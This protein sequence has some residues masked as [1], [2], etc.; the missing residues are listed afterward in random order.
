MKTITIVGWSA[1]ARAVVEEVT[2]WPDEMDKFLAIA[3]ATQVT[4]LMN[5][6]GVLVEEEEGNLTELPDLRPD[7]TIETPSDNT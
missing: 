7:N 3:K 4:D 1:K 5:I 6:E 2:T